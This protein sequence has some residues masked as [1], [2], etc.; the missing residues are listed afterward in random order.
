[1]PV[2]LNGCGFIGEVD[3]AADAC[4]KPPAALGFFLARAPES[5]RTPLSSRASAFVPRP[6]QAVATPAQP[7]ESSEVPVPG[8]ARLT[9]AAPAP[10]TVMLRNLP[11]RYTRVSLL[12]SLDTHGFAGLYDFVYLP[13]DFE[14][15]LCKG[16]AFVNATSGEHAQRMIESFDGYG[17]WSRSSSSKIC[18]ATLS[19]VQGLDANID[20]YRNSPVMGNGVPDIFKPALF[21]RG[22]EVP[23]PEPTRTVPLVQPRARPAALRG[24]LRARGPCAH[25]V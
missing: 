1:M 7:P 5:A 8:I 6:S 11:C 22:R 12:R 23:F 19:A 4:E 25:I 17:G 21:V 2:G 20:R 18:Q 9:P 16:Y 3:G 10:T 15:R 24:A 14:S 13:A